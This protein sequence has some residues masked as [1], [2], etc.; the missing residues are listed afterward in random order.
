MGVKKKDCRSRKL[1]K[2]KKSKKSDSQPTRRLRFESAY[3]ILNLVYLF[4][5]L[6][7]VVLFSRVNYLPRDTWDTMTLM[8]WAFDLGLINYLFIVEAFINFGVLRLRWR[9]ASSWVRL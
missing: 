4:I 9:A 7:W 3:V 8:T 5:Y 2:K 6:F 1:T